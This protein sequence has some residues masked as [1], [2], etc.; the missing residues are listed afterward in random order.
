MTV[1]AYRIDARAETREPLLLFAAG[2]GC[3]ALAAR[4]VNWRS[5][6]ITLAVGVAAWL[7]PP[8]REA[9]VSLKRC[10]SVF[11]LGTA[12]FLAVRLRLVALPY[13]GTALAAAASLAAAVA[14]EIFF[15]RLL[16]DALARWGAAVAVTGGALAFAAVHVPAYGFKVVPIDLA[17]GL[18]LGWQRWA[19]ETATVPAFTHVAAN[20]LSI[21]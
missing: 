15:R 16:Y 20:V 12:G 18:V 7:A 6:A 9:R 21:L 2:A 4:G 10:A 17:A 8:R 13:T 14:E 1:A 5:I 3:V 11:A 19:T